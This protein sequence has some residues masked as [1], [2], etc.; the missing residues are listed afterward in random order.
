MAVGLIKRDLIRVGVAKAVQ[1]AILL[2][3]R[4]VGS[5]GKE[6]GVG[7]LYILERLL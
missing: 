5:L 1:A 4:K 6:V 2:E 3:A 7:L